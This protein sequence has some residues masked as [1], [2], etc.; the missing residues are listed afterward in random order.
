MS[1]PAKGPTVLV[2][3]GTTST[4]YDAAQRRSRAE[5][6]ARRRAQ[7]NIYATREAARARGEPAR[8]GSLQLLSQDSPRLVLNFLNRDKSI[9]QQC[10]SEITLLPK[11]GKPGQ[12]EMMFSLVCPRC[13]A[14][15]VPQ[16]D[17]QLMVRDTHRRFW[18]DERRRGPVEVL[19]AGPD[20][21]ASKE[22]VFVAGTVTVN[23]IVRCSNVNC[24]FA[25]R[26]DNSHVV[27][28]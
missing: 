24:S 3:E 1:N 23:D 14:R 17:A 20:G 27:E 7:D 28:V 11:P 9:R 25:C 18:L 21:V 26:I 4:S 19:I 16:G 15:G 13:V 8:I 12:W 6:E 2:R 22:V 10:R 5:A